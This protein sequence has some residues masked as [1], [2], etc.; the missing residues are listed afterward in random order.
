MKYPRVQEMFEIANE[1]LGYNIKKIC[2]SGPQTTLNQTEY[3]QPATVLTS[4]AAAE[5][6]Q[7]ERPRAVDTCISAAGYSVGEI[8][9]L[10]FTGAISFEAG[11]KLVAVRAAAM[12][13]AS[14]MSPQGM[15]SVYCMPSAKLGS[16]TADAE[17]WALN[18]GVP[19]P[20]CR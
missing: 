7:D 15:M 8:T 16:L 11:M 12:Q 17:R 4:L 2:E 14:E 5:K 1:I 13:E 10:I 9:A 20:T 3:N 18:L 19:D 6:L